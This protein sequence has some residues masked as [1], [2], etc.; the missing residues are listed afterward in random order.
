MNVSYVI[1]TP[2]H[3]EAKFIEFTI[4]SVLSQT[5]L[6]ILWIIVNDGSTDITPEIVNRYT[7]DCQ[8]IKLVEMPRR[9]L[10]IRGGHVAEVFNFGYT[11]I[12][13]PYDFLV[14]LDGDVSFDE[15]YFETLFKEFSNKP[16][17]G[18]AGGGIYNKTPNGW[19]LEITPKDHVRGATKIYRRKCFEEIGGLE[20]VNGWDSIDEWRAQMRGWQTSTYEKVKVLHYRP[21]GAS[22][23]SLKRFVRQGEFAYYLGYPWGAIL[24]RTLFRS[25]IE[26]PI[27]IGGF[28]I[29]YG[30]LKSWLL[31]KPKFYDVELLNYVKKKQTQRLTSWIKSRPSM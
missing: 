18:I 10:R 9:T 6:P 8:W 30:F 21:T 29:F 23:G 4:H 7:Q 16:E 3:N 5:I 19:K 1:I 12:D 22:E 17:L 15:S 28:A 27:I 31:Q 14:K 26:R 11:F 13:T 25:F 20:P 2:V 24:A